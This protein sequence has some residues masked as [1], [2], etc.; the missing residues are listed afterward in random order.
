MR[1][2]GFERTLAAPETLGD[3]LFP[4]LE[5]YCARECRAHCD[6]YYEHHSPAWHE[7]FDSCMETC[8]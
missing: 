2:P 6:I 1:I 4:Q 5:S 3:R 8:H 7:C